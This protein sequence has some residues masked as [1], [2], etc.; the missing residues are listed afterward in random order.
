MLQGKCQN[1]C[2]GF[3][4]GYLWRLK[5]VLE[6]CGDPMMYMVHPSAL[7]DGKRGMN[8]HIKNINK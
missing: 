3:Q 5:K 2:Q 8:K 4:A 6:A 7:W 1:K